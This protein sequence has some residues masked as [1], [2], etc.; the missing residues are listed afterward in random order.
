MLIDVGGGPIDYSLTAA[1]KV[2]EQLPCLVFLHEG[3]GSV[4]L[5]R[6][7]PDAVRAACG[8]PAMLVYSR[9]GYGRSMV[10]PPPRSTDYMHREAQVVLP[11]LLSTLGIDRA[12]LVGHSDGASIALI[13]AGSGHPVSAIVAMTPHVFVEDISLV[14]ARAARSAFATTDLA[15]RLGRYHD[16]VSATFLGWNDV[17]LSEE[18]RRWNIEAFLPSISA[19]VLLIQG[20]ADEYG[21]LA[22]LDAIQQGV[23]G[24]CERLVLTGVGHAVQAVQAGQA[25]QAGGPAAVV[26]RIADF[27]RR[28]VGG[29]ASEASSGQTIVWPPPAATRL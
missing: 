24:P 12:V 22:Q 7:F 10:V 23:T 11:D 13:H 14:G 16:D 3:L 5:W 9:H 29:P 26:E 28:N 4:A 18:F 17:W 25:G 19:P 8:G 2:S 21:T 1:E 15:T 20:D 6:G 27:L